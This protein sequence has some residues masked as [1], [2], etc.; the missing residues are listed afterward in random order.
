MSAKKKKDS[1]QP[2][3]PIEGAPPAA[4]AQTAPA[5]KT[6]GTDGNGA[7]HVIAETVEAVVTSRLIRNNRRRA[8]HARGSRVSGLCQLRH[9]RPAIPNLADVSSRYNAASLWAL[10]EKDD[11]RFIKVAN[12]VGHTMQYHPHGDASIGDALVVL[13]NKRYLIEVREI[14]ATSSPAIRGCVALHRVPAHGTGPHEVFND[15]ITEFIPQLRRAQQRNRCRCLAKLP[16]TLMLGTE[17]IAVGLSA[18]ILSHNFPNCWK[19]RSR[20]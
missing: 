2:E 4:P 18:R 11:G 15:S 1:G 12:V 10:H 20:F 9:S 13:A 19:R 3:L 17:G 8:A 14:S 16:L 5:K 6:S 7:D